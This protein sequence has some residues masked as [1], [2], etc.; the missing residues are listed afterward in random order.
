M[1]D[2]DWGKVEREQLRVEECV[3]GINNCCLKF[4][5]SEEIP[6]VTGDRKANSTLRKEEK[7]ARLLKVGSVNKATNYYYYYYYRHYY[8]YS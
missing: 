4:W 8:Y 7:E 5:K 1:G 3:A 2:R 6:R